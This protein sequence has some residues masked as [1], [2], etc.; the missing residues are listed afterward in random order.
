MIKRDIEAIKWAVSLL[1]IHPGIRENPNSQE[2]LARLRAM[3]PDKKKSLTLEE[4]QKLLGAGTPIQIK[5][6]PIDFLIPG[7]LLAKI[8]AAK[9]KKP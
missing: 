7:I 2:W 8:Y 5:V 6:Q 4:T 1:E 9:R 3:L